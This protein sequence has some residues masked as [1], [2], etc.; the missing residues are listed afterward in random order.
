[1]TITLI[2]EDR[3]WLEEKIRQ[4]FDSPVELHQFHKYMDCIKRARRFGFD[5]LV[6]EMQK[7]LP[8]SSFK[9]ENQ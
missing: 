6:D 5:E 8:Y 1:M 7:D 9:K 2:Q 3:K 4:E